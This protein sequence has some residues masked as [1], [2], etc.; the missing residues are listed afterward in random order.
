[1]TRSI[2]VT[3]RVGA[4]LVLLGNALVLPML[5]RRLGSA[6]LVS[7]WAAEA[8]WVRASANGGV[9]LLAA[10]VVILCVGLF[11]WCRSGE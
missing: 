7:T 10:G 2:R 8:F 1:M 11:A 3:L 5:V 4:V 9:V 6:A